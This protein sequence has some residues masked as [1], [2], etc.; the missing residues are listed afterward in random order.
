M[1][2]LQLSCSWGIRIHLCTEEL[3]HISCEAA[4]FITLLTYQNSLFRIQINVLTTFLCPLKQA[5]VNAV[6]PF[7]SLAL[8]SIFQYK[9]VAN[10]QITNNNRFS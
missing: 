10:L 1:Q 2:T 3:R 7:L 9:N 6:H 4:T 5:I 8:K